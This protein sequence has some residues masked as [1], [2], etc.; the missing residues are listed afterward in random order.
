MKTCRDCHVE[1]PATDFYPHPRMADGRLNKCKT[2]VK[3][4][5]SRHRRN[6][7][8][9]IRAYD[10][11]RNRL[12]HRLEIR[13]KYAKTEAG[14]RVRA[15]ANSAWRQREPEKTA[16]HTILNHAI[17]DGKVK[18]GPCSVCGL[19]KKIHG[20]HEDYSK[21]LDVIWVCDK[22]HKQIHMNKKKKHNVRLS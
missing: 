13:R 7:I 6:N 15:T 20:H 2:C 1:K 12:P 9:K 21:P 16:A 10:Q 5:I 4:R 8:E 22:H 11:I 17:R 3:A 19:K 18:K 14:K